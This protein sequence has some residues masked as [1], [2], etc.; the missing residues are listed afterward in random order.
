M[1]GFDCTFVPGGA[2]SRG[3]GGEGHVVHSSTS[4]LSSIWCTRA[5]QSHGSSLGVRLCLEICRD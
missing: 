4:T 2:V 3:A 5:L 1:S